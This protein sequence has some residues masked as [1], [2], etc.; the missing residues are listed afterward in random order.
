MSSRVSD[1]LT[2]TAPKSEFSPQ[3]RS[4][5]SKRP[6]DYRLKRAEIFMT[7]HDIMM[8]EIVKTAN[9]L[10]KEP[11]QRTTPKTGLY[12]NLGKRVLDTALTVSYTHLTR[13]T[14]A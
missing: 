13:P 4:Q 6:W 10:R 14:K 5:T 1:K 8:T 11:S 3:P 7:G 12:R 9:V 2:S